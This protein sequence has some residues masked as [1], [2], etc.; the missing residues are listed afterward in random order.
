MLHTSL[1]IRGPDHT[2]PQGL[3]SQAVHCC[4]PPAATNASKCYSHPIAMTR[5]HSPLRGAQTRTH[6]YCICHGCKKAL[7]TRYGQMSHFRMR[8]THSA[9]SRSACM[10]A[11]MRTFSAFRQSL[12][13]LR[14]A[15]GH[16]TLLCLR[17]APGRGAGAQHNPASAVITGCVCGGCVGV[18]VPKALV[19]AAAA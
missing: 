13:L 2:H 10:P 18:G 11:S 14:P 5:S 19:R 16:N 3:P 17:A 8:L 4:A 9:A 1:S 12:T 6:G 15:H 7:H